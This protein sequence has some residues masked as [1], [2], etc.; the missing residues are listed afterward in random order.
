M[1]SA[2]QL[3][4]LR[5]QF[6]NSLRLMFPCLRDQFVVV[7]ASYLADDANVL[8]SD[9]IKLA[10][11]D[12]IPDIDADGRPLDGDFAAVD[13]GGWLDHSPDVGDGLDHVRPS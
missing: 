8:I 4:S 7:L 3:L 5:K 1:L 2:N 10:S 6:L 9:E 11:H 12:G 13:E